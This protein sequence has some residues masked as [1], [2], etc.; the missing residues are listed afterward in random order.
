M[1]EVAQEAEVGGDVGNGV[2]VDAME[3]DQGVEDQEPRRRG[4]VRNR[5]GARI[6]AKCG[7]IVENICIRLDDGYRKISEDDVVASEF[8]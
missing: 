7:Q 2:L 6:G 5:Q 1:S 8:P 4:S 3:A